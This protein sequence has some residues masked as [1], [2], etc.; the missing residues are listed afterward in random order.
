[1][2]YLPKL[3]GVHA[4]EIIDQCHFWNWMYWGQIGQ[5]CI[6][7]WRIFT[8]GGNINFCQDI[9]SCQQWGQSQDNGTQKDLEDFA[10]GGNINFWGQDIISCQH[11]GHLGQSRDSGTRRKD[12]KAI[13]VWRSFFS[14]GGTSNFLSQ[15]N[16]NKCR[17]QATQDSDR[18]ENQE[19]LTIFGEN[20][21]LEGLILWKMVNHVF[22]PA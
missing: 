22:N 12:W 17:Q 15:K 6:I 16:I 18:G 4:K 19:H 7:Q 14:C 13:T 11:L 1:M 20:M 21:N 10:C 5:K 9:N 3:I 8:C 2:R